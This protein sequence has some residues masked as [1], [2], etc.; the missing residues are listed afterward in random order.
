M[1]LR[2]ESLELLGGLVK[3]NLRRLGLSHLLLKLAGLSSN[4]N[5]QFLDLEGKFLNLGLISS[6]VLFKGKVILFLLPG[7]KCPLFQLF[8]VPVH[9]QFEL[10]HLLVCLK[11]HVL[12]VVESVLLVSDPVVQLFDFILEPST[13]SLCD[14]FHVFLRLDLLVLGIDQ[15]LGVHKLHL[16]RLKMLCQDL[17][18]LLMLFDLESKLGYESYLFSDLISNSKLI[19]RFNTNSN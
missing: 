19:P 10:I 8:L 5:S 3:L 14:L 18:S 9:L 16:D 7:S 2:M 6:S 1:S 4:L 15:T 12:D 11:D 13:L 17:E